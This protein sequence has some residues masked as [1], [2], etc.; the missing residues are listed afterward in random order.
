MIVTYADLS[1]PLT[2]HDASD[3]SPRLRAALRGNRRD[4][5]IRACAAA[6]KGEYE[7]A[8]CLALDAM[9]GATGEHR[10]ELLGAAARWFARGDQ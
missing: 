6:S 8:A 5:A 10:A 2:E 3:F 9:A 7:R 1:R 4:I